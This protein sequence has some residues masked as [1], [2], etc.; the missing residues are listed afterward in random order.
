MCFPNVRLEEGAR[1]KFA[2]PP[3]PEDGEQVV[4]RWENGLLRDVCLDVR[5]G[6]YHCPVVDGPDFVLRLLLP[7]SAPWMSSARLQPQIRAAS[8]SVWGPKTSPS[9]ASSM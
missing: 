2:V 5:V 9:A 7:A 3:Y 1:T 8:C 6:A 4:D